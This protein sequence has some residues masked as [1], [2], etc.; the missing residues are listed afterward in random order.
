MKIHRVTE[1]SILLIACLVVA[2]TDH[3][4]FI[5]TNL[6]Q[7]VKDNRNLWLLAT[8]LAYLIIILFFSTIYYIAYKKRTDNFIFQ[9]DILKSRF[10][11]I[12]LKSTIALDDA[13]LEV[14][15]LHQIH[16][17]MK[18][19]LEYNVVKE[20]KTL[21]K[22]P[23]YQCIIKFFDGVI[24]GGVIVPPK[25]VLTIL[26]KNSGMLILKRD[27]T[28]YSGIGNKAGKIISALIT[29]KQALVE[30]H[31]E[32]LRAL[33]DAT[34]K[35]WNYFDFLYFSAI[36][37]TTVGY[38]DILPNSTLVRLFVLCQIVSGL[39]ILV[40]IANLIFQSI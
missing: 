6:I 5:E 11:S 4:L 34:P 35:V 26:S 15:A 8:F 30:E 12:E 31:S 21:I 3:R 19:E 14:A 2:C 28:S 38:G 29:E 36:T 27:V 16:S 23:E 32:I 7:A 9:S 22:S 37:Q 10:M 18:D 24:D 17:V 20:R 1:K 39:A 13:R 33:K 25:L 40:V